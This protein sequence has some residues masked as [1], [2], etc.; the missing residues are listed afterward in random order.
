MK[1]KPAFR[2]P[3]KMAWVAGL[4]LT[5]SLAAN[6]ALPPDQL[7]SEKT[8][9]I[10]TVPDLIALKTATKN[11][12]QWKFLHDPALKAFRD[13][14]WEGISEN[15]LKPL[16]DEIQFKVSSGLELLQG[17]LTLAISV[18]GDLNLEDPQVG[19]LMILDAGKNKA[20][21][22]SI[23]DDAKSRMKASEIPFKE[24]MI[25]GAR[26]IE[27]PNDEANFNLLLGQSDELLL[28]GNSEEE[29]DKVIARQ[30]GGSVPSL[31]RNTQFQSQKA[32]LFRDSLVY[33]WIHLEP[34]VGAIAK[35]MAA[36]EAEN[37]PNP[38]GVSPAAVL[39][40]LGLTGLVDASFGYF[41]KPDGA[42]AEMALGVP[43]SKRQGLFKMLASAPNDSAPPPFVPGNVDSFSRWR[44][45]LNKV[46]SDIEAMVGQ[47]SPLMTGMMQISLS[48]IGKQT[49]PNFDFKRN[50]IG[51]L[52]DDLISFSQAPGGA[53]IEAIASQPALFLL[54]SRDAV[55]L[56]AAVNTMLTE[57]GLQPTSTKFLGRTIYSIAT[58]SADF[59][60]E[61]GQMSFVASDGY[62]AI[63]SDRGIMETFLRSGSENS[64]ERPLR[65]NAE[66]GA[67]AAKIGGLRTGLFA[68][69][70]DKE[71]VKSVYNMI[72]ENPEFIEMILAEATSELEVGGDEDVEPSNW[73]DISLLPPFS[74]LEKYFNI[75]VI[76]G[77]VEPVGFRLKAFTPT[78]PG[79]D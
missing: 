35:Q 43:Q 24:K 48:Q 1:S 31:A 19:M 10:V 47:I 52:G 32:A 58:P 44:I 68:F 76:T 62:L 40:A 16:E 38:M 69:Q 67:A 42:Y 72:R 17:Q 23:L 79:L 22:T 54:G 5:M 30:K 9:A 63:A 74:R 75:S 4:A 39:K 45:D 60:S 18:D 36:E 33:G 61:G 59:D 71:S 53:S 51:N 34:V 77:S 15:I 26:F 27:I 25:R 6:G 49:D 66:M 2:L 7:V 41:E 11:S 73:I 37:G 28:V 70:N 55:Q 64:N 14:L 46:W 12:A 3:R 21:L 8:V 50:F 78:P 29:L 65:S 57:F 13:K 20:Q 56:A